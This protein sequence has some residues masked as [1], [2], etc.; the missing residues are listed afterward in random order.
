MGSSL[1]SFGLWTGSGMAGCAAVN[2][3][4]MQRVTELIA[5]A[6]KTYCITGV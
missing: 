5:M 2:C 3:P 6:V 1:F 4:D